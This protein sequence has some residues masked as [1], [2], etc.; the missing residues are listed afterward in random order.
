M[1]LALANKRGCCSAHQTLNEGRETVTGLDQ[2]G[3]RWLS[4][5]A[6]VCLNPLSM[7]SRQLLPVVRLLSKQSNNDSIVFS[8]LLVDD[9]ASGL[10]L[11]C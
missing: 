10:I 11:V 7:H 2:V 3:K 5:F 4:F 8:A 1:V 6:V 9:I